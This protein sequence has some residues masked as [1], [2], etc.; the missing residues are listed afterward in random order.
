MAE[1]QLPRLYEQRAK[2]LASLDIWLERLSNEKLF[3]RGDERR[4]IRKI[5]N[6]IDEVDK[7]I[8][9][10]EKLEEKF[11]YLSTA[12]NNGLDPRG[13]VAS[14]IGSAVGNVANAAS[15]A[16]GSIQIGK[17]TRNESIEHTKRV[18]ARNPDS[19]STPPKINIMLIIG[20]A[21]VAVFM[22]KNE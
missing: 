8:K 9:K 3:K 22:L 17:S 19:A 15:S 2:L 18:I 13:S 1:S 11:D 6:E 16:L 7:L 14:S 4:A 20:A 21:L 10:V 5:R 12:A